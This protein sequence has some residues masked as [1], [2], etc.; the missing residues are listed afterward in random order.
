MPQSD[1]STK[2]TKPIKPTKS[3]K[4]IK[5]SAPSSELNPT[6]NPTLNP[7]STFTLNTSTETKPMQHLFII[8]G[9]GMMSC[10]L[11]KDLLKIN[12]KNKENLKIIGVDVSLENLNKAKELKIIEESYHDENNINNKN[13][14]IY[15]KIKEN[16]L[17]PE[18]I[19]KHQT[20]KITML[21]AAPVKAFPAIFKKLNALNLEASVIEK[22]IITDVGSTK[23]II[24]DASQHLGTLQN[25]F[26]PAHPIAGLETSGPAAAREA[27]FK[28]KWCYVAQEKNINNKINKIYNQRRDEIIKMWKSVG[29][30]IFSMNADE[31][32]ILFAKLSHAPHFIA[33]AAAHAYKNTKN[34]N[35]NNLNDL[36]IKKFLRIAKSNAD[37]WH[38]IA[39][40][41]PE[42][43]LKILN[44][45]YSGMHKFN[46][47][48]V[49]NNINNINNL[50]DAIKNPLQKSV[51]AHHKIPNSQK[52]SAVTNTNSNN[53][54]QQIKNLK[55]IK[56]LPAILFAIIVADIYM[57]TIIQNSKDKS[58][59]KYAGTGLH[60]FT[61]AL[62]IFG[63]LD[64]LKTLENN[65]EDL[66]NILIKNPNV[67]MQLQT[68][69]NAFLKDLEKI[70]KNIKVISAKVSSEDAQTKSANASKALKEY[71]N[72]IK[73]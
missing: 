44:N 6:L 36:Y 57:Q 13:N 8:F 16:Y 50:I 62:K 49:D 43:I 59:L 61:A 42:N 33:F 12:L 10:S 27:L 32:D 23:K 7:S 70:Y 45:F 40:D 73:I 47:K 48:I 69:S 38:D 11:A 53:I 52:A 39:R 56:D 31:H 37:M 54:N 28:K 4:P 71:I 64:N 66:K 18:L 65:L 21:I 19:E 46:L 41:N 25:C 51:A 14:N 29:A 2:P 63:N 68:L 22:L 60:D 17:T 67:L 35:K 72:D 3:V 55:N 1:F 5:N 15:Y 34:L 58:N 9:V 26:I 30:T 24:T 20:Q